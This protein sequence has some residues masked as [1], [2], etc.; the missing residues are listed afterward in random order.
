LRAGM[1]R[2]GMRQYGERG[3]GAGLSYLERL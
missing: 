2:A 1:S 3:H